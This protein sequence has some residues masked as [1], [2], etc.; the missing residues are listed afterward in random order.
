MEERNITPEESLSIIQQMI[1]NS[2]E[3]FA[4]N[5]FSFLLWGFL[6]IIGCLITYI[7]IWLKLYHVI[8]SAWI[9]L[10]VIGTIW[11]V[12]IILRRDKKNRYRSQ[13]DFAGQ[14]LWMGF[15]ISWVITVFAIGGNNTHNPN[16]FILVLLGL[17][18]F[19]S[20]ALMQFRPLYFGGVIFWIAAIIANYLPG[21]QSML[22][23]AAA[24]FT[25]YII[26][27]WLLRQKVRREK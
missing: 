15:L 6:V 9:A 4:N 26:P 10:M 22:L 18:T 24:M 14:M 11:T 7:C 27:G 16:A 12:T 8:N 3:R 25:G 21:S 13:V 23:V 1:Q 19:V 2:R 20:G 5:G 17:C